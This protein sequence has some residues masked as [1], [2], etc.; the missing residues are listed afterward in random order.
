VFYEVVT[1]IAASQLLMRAP[2]ILQATVPD[3]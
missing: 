3:N 1:R 2:D